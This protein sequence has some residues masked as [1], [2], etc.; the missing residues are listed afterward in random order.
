MLE[1]FLVYKANNL[2]K[3]TKRC[4]GT[5]KINIR[6]HLELATLSSDAAQLTDTIHVLV[7]E[8]FFHWEKLRII[9]MSIKYRI[10]K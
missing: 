4:I 6:T 5:E 3:K 7:K 2:N 1:L 10:I 9:F 8:L